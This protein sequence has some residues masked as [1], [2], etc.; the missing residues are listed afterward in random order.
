MTTTHELLWC[1][2]LRSYCMSMRRDWKI[3]TN[4]NQTR[5][6]REFVMTMMVVR[7]EPP[8]FSQWAHAHTIFFSL[9]FTPGISAKRTEQKVF[10][11]AWLWNNKY[12]YGEQRNV[13]RN[14]SILSAQFPKDDFNDIFIGC[15]LL[16]HMINKQWYSWIS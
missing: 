3:I 16:F 13:L 4:S 5:I 6:S 7:R 14:Q 11:C 1:H 2:G 9:L 12:V 8:S 10:E 15:K